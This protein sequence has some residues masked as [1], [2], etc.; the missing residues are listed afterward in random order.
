MTCAV[1][2]S[3][4]FF[5][6]GRCGIT[7]R[8]RV[9][10]AARWAGRTWWA[11]AAAWPVLKAASGAGDGY[12]R[13]WDDPTGRAESRVEGE[14]YLAIRYSGTPE[15]VHAASAGEHLLGIAAMPACTPGS[16]AARV[17]ALRVPNSSCP[18]AVVRRLPW[19]W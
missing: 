3:R 16:P 5:Y 12:Y 7:P 17:P 8:K 13:Y 18:P 11:S 15:T 1:P 9:P 14:G 2:P 10:C 6:A 4:A 19:R